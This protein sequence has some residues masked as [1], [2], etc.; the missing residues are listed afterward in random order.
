MN[1]NAWRTP[2]VRASQQVRPLSAAMTGASSGLPS[3]R[4]KAGSAGPTMLMA[5]PPGAITV[6]D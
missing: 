4:A 3:W 1:R 2:R 6:S 5:S